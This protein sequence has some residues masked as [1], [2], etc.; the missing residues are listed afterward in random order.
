MLL[1]GEGRAGQ[2]LCG[3]TER[4]PEPGGRDGERERIRGEREKP[5]A[6]SEQQT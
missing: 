6:Q 5:E 2:R 4:H 1:F 3:E